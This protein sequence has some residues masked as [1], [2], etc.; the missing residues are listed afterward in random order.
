MCRGQSRKCK[1][2]DMSG[3]ELAFPIL[4]H[5]QRVLHNLSRRREY[6]YKIFPPNQ[7]VDRRDRSDVIGKRRSLVVDRFNHERQ[8]AFNPLSADIPIPSDDMCSGVVRG[9]RRCCA[10]KCRVCGRQ[11][12][13]G[14]LSNE[15]AC[16][17]VLLAC[18]ISL[19]I[20][21]ALKGE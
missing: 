20:R 10:R 16:W 9:C 14:L 18:T 8:K 19:I 1:L 4:N 17:C 5:R 13:M 6:R 3:L 21:G 11:G 7:M 2:V 15:E 12:S